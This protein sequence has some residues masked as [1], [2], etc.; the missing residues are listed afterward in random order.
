MLLNFTQKMVSGIRYM[1]K[2]LPGYK[3][4]QILVNIAKSKKNLH[5]D[6]LYTSKVLQGFKKQAF[7]IAF[8]KLI[9]VNLHMKERT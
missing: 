5:T 7:A 3:I 9:K 1:P 4:S 6:K 8:V 2:R